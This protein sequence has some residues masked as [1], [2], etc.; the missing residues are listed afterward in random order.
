MAVKISTKIKEWTQFHLATGKIDYMSLNRL[1]LNLTADSAISSRLS[2]TEQTR[3]QEEKIRTIIKEEAFSFESMKL[4]LNP[5]KTT[6]LTALAIFHTD[7]S[8]RLSYRV[9]G[10]GEESDYSYVYPTPVTTHVCPIFGLYPDTDNL[11]TMELIATE[12]N[13]LASR[14]IRI[15]TGP[16]SDNILS[17]QEESGYPLLRDD[18]GNIRYYLNVPAGDIGIVPIS[19]QRF[20]LADAAIR[21]RT[22]QMP[23]PTHLYEFDL[24]GRFYRTYYVG[25]GI[26]DIVGEKEAGENLYLFTPSY[27]GPE[28]NL[29]E[30][31]RQTGAVVKVTATDQVAKNYSGRNITRQQL[32]TLSDFI[33]RDFAA[34]T[35]SFTDILYPVSGWL[36]TPVPYKGASIETT[37]GISLEDMAK[38]HQMRF[39][40][41]GDTLLVSTM[42]HRLQEILF[43]RT[44]RVYQLD[45]TFPAL[46]DEAYEDYPYLLAVPF[47][48]MYSGTYS[49]VLRFADGSQEV[50]K[51]TITLSRTRQTV[52]PAN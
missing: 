16:V 46:I 24:L 3:K 18:E 51:D 28:N 26:A 20:L 11:V 36:K 12:G 15:K 39:S 52:P 41:Y 9:Q 1:R 27:S 14:T 13:T 35:E 21:T 49:V 50:L 6:P 29:L 38:L 22:G 4:I 2:L 34:G 17:G 31:N 8:C 47:T 5:Y 19:D 23:L 44:D 25:N 43:A 40:L 48:E 42:G 37:E 32:D 45:L 30:L 33:S 10:H 7:F